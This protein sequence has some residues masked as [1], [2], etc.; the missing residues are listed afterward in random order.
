MTFRGVIQNG[1]V[2]LTEA[3]LPEGTPVEV[4]TV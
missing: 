1:K 3:S 4:R 2:V